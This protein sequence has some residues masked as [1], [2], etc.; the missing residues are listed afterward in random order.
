M[1]AD[2][3]RLVN[4]INHGILPFA[5]RSEH[6]QEL[7]SFWRH[8]L[9][10]QELRALL[11]V[12][13]AGVG[14]SR[15]L[16]EATQSVENEGG[17]VIRIKLIAES[18]ASVVPLLT[19][20]LWYNEKVRHL[21]KTDLHGS[22]TAVTTWLRRIARLRPTMLIVEDIHLLPQD[23][24]PELVSLLEAVAE[25][26]LAMVCSARPMELPARGL[27]ERF[28][29]DEIRLNGLE[30]SA[31]DSLWSDLFQC[32]PTA[33]V[34]D[35]V[36][37]ATGG[38]PFAIRNALRSAIKS[39]ALEQDHLTDSWRP[40]TSV[41]AL[42]LGMQ[43]SAGLLAEGMAATLSE[44]ERLSAATLA[45][46]GEVFAIE[47]ARELMPEAD[48]TV[49]MLT[50]KGILVTSSTVPPPLPG[51]ASARPLMTFTH[52]LLHQHLASLAPPFTNDALIAIANGS[53]LYSTHPFQK[54]SAGP[55]P[56]DVAPAT[57][58]ALLNRGLL[59]ARHLDRGPTW[60]EAVDVWSA[61][62]AFLHLTTALWHADEL[63]VARARLLVSRLSLM[64]RFIDRPEYAAMV[65]EALSHTEREVTADGWGEARL[66]VLRWHYT[67]TAVTA[68]PGSHEVLRRIE[69][70]VE[71]HP[72]L[73]RTRAYI[74]TLRS[75]AEMAARI[76]DV[77]MLRHLEETVE[78]MLAEDD[79]PA[80]LRAIALQ[81][82]A[83][84]FLILFNTPEEFTKRQRLLDLILEE[85]DRGDD[86]IFVR[87]LSF[88]E[89]T[90]Q[91]AAALRASEDGIERSRRLGLARTAFQCT[92]TRLCAL[93][94]LGAD[95]RRIEEE[96]W[97]LCSTARLEASRE[98]SYCAIY[99]AE[100]GLL[101]N[102]PRWTR[103]MLDRFGPG[104][105]DRWLPES[106]LLALAE[107]APLE[108]IAIGDISD[109]DS[110][111]AEEALRRLAAAM[112][113][114]VK[115]IEESL[116][117]ALE[118]IAA[119]PILRTSDLLLVTA[120]LA[121]ADAARNR[122]VKPGDS[123]AA[124]LSRALEWLSERGLGGYLAA[125]AGRFAHHLGK[126][127]L[128]FWRGRAAE[129]TKDYAEQ[130]P[131][132]RERRHRVTMIG[133]MAVTTPEGEVR[134]IRGARLKTMLGLLVAARMVAKPLSNNEFCRLAAGGE[135]EID[136]ARKT[137]NMAVVRLR[138]A[139]GGELI[140][141]GEETHELNLDMVTVDLLEA[142][143]QLR[144]A[145][146]ALR[147][148]ALM[149]AYPAV[150]KALAISRG[151]VTF[152]GLYDDF[153]EALR[154]DFENRQRTATLDVARALIAEN[155][156]ESASTLLKEAFEWMPDDEEIAALLRSALE[157]SGRRTDAEL[158]RL[159]SDAE[160][161]L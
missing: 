137:M 86:Q 16:D 28:L 70:F 161:E 65:E 17:T 126:R 20:A 52:S 81:E 76:P 128:A 154:E 157:Q 68:Y 47:T 71:A 32:R 60:K 56:E 29:A 109:H 25:E 49:N 140:R 149:L 133:A 127:D 48:R 57:L 106:I 110:T 1:I 134:P 160:L 138:E 50:F 67:H 139:I 9:D 122:R 33:G 41:E 24:V 73:R 153:F 116:A 130:A 108:T 30:R 23:A 142:D 148:R 51:R 78:R 100:V 4:F 105:G 136:L 64:R 145:V 99:L 120:T 146:S 42:A 74:I 27:L 54:L 58:H 158:I 6:L 53:P 72:A 101:R 34:V 156:A 8:T 22:P 87:R 35:A 36:E 69:E 26:T 159:R 62:E 79:L 43:R 104:D 121:L 45:S 92:L 40:A 141:T 98:R 2:M 132:S 150:M 55:L 39:G 11:L 96:A 59:I 15:L 75:V 82:V 129:L 117:A 95:L 77:T 63:M 89:S 147:R 31:I 10:A 18:G 125:L 113:G 103:A 107:D 91:M 83:P 7:V 66:G 21:L 112:A 88:L 84:Q 61:C 94:A 14:K 114:S 155:D 38:N 131:A 80:E 90:G 123:F 143:E 118:S 135:L 152:P 19:Q 5:G 102:E 151:E 3:D 97:T 93:G 119:Q 44:A 37:R 115:G 13:E 144:Q 111:T 12:G 124:T 85:A 46:I